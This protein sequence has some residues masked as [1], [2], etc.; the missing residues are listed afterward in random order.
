MSPGDIITAN[1]PM[2]IRAESV[3]DSRPEF[4]S[5]KVRIL[6]VSFVPWL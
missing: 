3:Q 6:P 5:L 1:L 4:H 2:I